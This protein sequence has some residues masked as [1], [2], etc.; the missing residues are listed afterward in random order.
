MQKKLF[1]TVTLLTVSFG[2]LSAAQAAVVPNGTKLA[3]NQILN[4]DNSSEPSSLDP[5]RVRDNLGANVVMDLFESLV[6]DDPMGNIIPAGATH[7]DINKGGTKYTFHLRKNAKWSDGSPVLADD[8]VY[9]FKRFVNPN[10]ASEMAYL[11]NMIKNAQ[12]IVDG[13]AN[14]ETLGVKALDNFTLE[15][16]LEQPTPYFLS[17]LTGVNFVP[18]KK[19]VVEKYKSDWTQSLHIVGNGAYKLKSWKIGDHI[20][21]EKN[22]NY[23]DSKNTVI[24][25]VNFYATQDKT[26]SLRMFQAGQ[27]DWTYGIPPGQLESIKKQYPKEL[28]NAPQLASNYISFNTEKPPF[29]NKKLREALSLVVNRESF[30]KYISGKNET[31]LYDIVPYGIANYTPYVPTWS[32]MSDKELLAKAQ[33]LYKEAGYSK[34][35]PA[36]IKFTYATNETDRK[37]ATALASIWEKALGTK[38]ELISEEWKVHLSYLTSKNYQVTL[39]LYGADYNDAQNFIGLLENGNAQ[40]IT[41]YNKKEFNVLLHESSKEMNPEKRKQ[42]LSSAAKMAMD[43]FPVSPLF[44]SKI[45]RLIKTYV[46]GVTFV[47]P[48]DNYRTKDLYIVSHDGNS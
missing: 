26:T 25:T 6:I 14:P 20:S 10:T 11:A 15:I 32:K 36:R 42:I 43:D 31:P 12:T 19:D 37:Y 21:L 29:N 45:Y 41:G 22:P 47:S 46:Q 27:L 28:R 40:N 44:S 24:N 30:T 4:K 33:Q 18:L 5:S 38:T 8:Y 17:V 7:W 3:K 1:K 23:W 13:K 39:Q 9:S 35:N 34:E 16:T 48:Q 2:I